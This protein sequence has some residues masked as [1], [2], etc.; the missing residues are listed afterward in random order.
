MECCKSVGANGYGKRE[1]YLGALKWSTHDDIEAICG[2]LTASD[3]EGVVFQK[4]KEYKDPRSAQ[5]VAAFLPN[6]FKQQDAIAV[7]QAIGASAEKAVIPYAAKFA[8]N[9]VETNLGAR[10]A[11]IGLL[12]DI[13]TKESIPVLKQIAQEFGLTNP[14]TT[15]I[16]KILNRGKK[17]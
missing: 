6:F 7:L 1:A 12:G 15:A 9:G 16:N 3:G 14:A 8:P 2:L 11:I 4:L 17:K 13:G 10:I 5:S